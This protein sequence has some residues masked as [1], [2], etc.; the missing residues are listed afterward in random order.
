MLPTRQSSF[1][2]TEQQKQQ[3]RQ[4]ALKEALLEVAHVEQRHADIPLCQETADHEKEGAL[5]LE[6]ALLVDRPGVL[7]A[8]L[9]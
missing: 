4:R 7:D 3:Q 8:R 5:A 1:R 6:R 2:Q 9:Q